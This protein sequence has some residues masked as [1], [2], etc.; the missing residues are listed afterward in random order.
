MGKVLS[1]EL[2]E[3]I[4]NPNE[5]ELGRLAH[6]VGRALMEVNGDRQAISKMRVEL[7]IYHELPTGTPVYSALVALSEL[8]SGYMIEL[9]ECL[10][11]SEVRAVQENPESVRLWELLDEKSFYMTIPQIVEGLSLDNEEVSRLLG[12]NSHA[13]FL[14]NDGVGLALSFKGRLALKQ[15]KEEQL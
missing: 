9:D 8:C 14:E 12:N 7:A 10:Y 3:F 2:D 1:P 15:Y 6:M 4:A 11:R 13:G 5:S